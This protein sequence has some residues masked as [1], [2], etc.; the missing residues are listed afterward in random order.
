MN[1]QV[2]GWSEVCTF[3]SFLPMEAKWEGART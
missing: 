2:E 3:T 1:W